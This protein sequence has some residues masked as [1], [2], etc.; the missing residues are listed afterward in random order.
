LDINLTRRELPAGFFMEKKMHLQT[1]V[2]DTVTPVSAFLSLQESEHPPVYLLESVEKSG[3]SGRFSFIGAGLKEHISNG[4]GEGLEQF[5]SRL[6]GEIKGLSTSD[7]PIGFAGF[8]S[9]NSLNGDLRQ[10]VP[11]GAAH[12]VLPRFVLRFDHALRQLSL[13]SV[14]TDSSVQT[15]GETLLQQVLESGRSAKP[16]VSETTP[17][18]GDETLEEII[19]NCRDLILDAQ[20]FQI[21]ASASVSGETG[22]SPIQLYRGLRYLFPSPYMFLFKFQ[23]LAA[24]GSSPGSFL[25]IENNQASMSVLSGIRKGDPDQMDDENFLTALRN[26]P[27]EQAKHTVLVDKAQDDLARICR[28]ETVRPELNRRLDHFSR[29]LHLESR[30]TGR[31]KDEIDMFSAFTRVFP[32]STLCGA[33]KRAALARLAEAGKCDYPVFGGAAGHFSP[34]GR[35]DH[36]LA[37]RTIVLNDGRFAAT[38]GALITAQSDAAEEAESIH[39]KNRRLLRAFEIAREI[40]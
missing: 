1:T 24:M 13:F 5:T 30:L 35:M 2:N 28:P 11:A 38:S 19:T 15:E 20:V 3:M 22:I 31:L 39:Q 7:L 4:E 37:V 40:R 33:P 18:A 9:L 10:S 36:A 23:E 16:A 29:E 32:S 27:Q 34:G 25:K 8:T 12:Y 6:A 17:N 14:A 26:D 21:L